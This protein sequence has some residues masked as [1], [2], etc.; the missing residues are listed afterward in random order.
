M[1]WAKYKNTASFSINDDAIENVS[2][3]L[4][5]E[6][7]NFDDIFPDTI[8]LDIHWLI[9]EREEFEDEHPELR[10]RQAVRGVSYRYMSEGGEEIGGLWWDETLDFLIE[11]PEYA[12]LYEPVNFYI[13]DDEEYYVPIEE[14]IEARK[15]ELNS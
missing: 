13:S 4:K 1:D 5:K 3:E 11:H 2:D 10:D 6:I 12:Q 8:T 14:L 9:P 7:I 15:K